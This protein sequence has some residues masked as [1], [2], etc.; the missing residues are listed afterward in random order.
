VSS[1]HA[2]G[3]L[4][5]SDVELAVGCLKD[6]WKTAYGLNGALGSFIL[7]A[8]LWLEDGIKLVFNGLHSAI[9]S[10]LY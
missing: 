1:A 9:D 4:F 7:N 8:L 3:D 5:R 10:A 2:V 6:E